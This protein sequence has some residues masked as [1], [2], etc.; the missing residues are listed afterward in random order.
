MYVCQQADHDCLGH[1]DRVPE[2]EKVQTANGLCR[3]TY[4]F[5]G[6]VEP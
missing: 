5:S 3:L 6:L 2:S 4:D 1:A